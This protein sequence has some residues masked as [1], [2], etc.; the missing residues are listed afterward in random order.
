VLPPPENIYAV[1]SKMQQ[2]Q[3]TSRLKTKTQA[4]YEAKSLFD[5]S[6]KWCKLTIKAHVGP[7]KMCPNFEDKDTEADAISLG[8]GHIDYGSNKRPDIRDMSFLE[9]VC[10]RHTTLG[11]GGGQRLTGE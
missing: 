11:G 10:T 2:K 1:V 3:M 8:L 9:S 7:T 5:W 4:H 6:C